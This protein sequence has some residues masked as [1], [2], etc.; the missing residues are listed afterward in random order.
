MNQADWFIVTNWI[1]CEILETE[2]TNK[3]QYYSKAWLFFIV[4]Y[5]NDFFSFN[6][7]IKKIRVIELSMKEWNGMK[8]RL[9]PWNTTV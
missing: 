8:E 1:Y 9:K 7:Q 3:I 6:T 4:D 2:I 5:K